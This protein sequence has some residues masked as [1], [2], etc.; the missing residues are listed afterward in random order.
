MSSRYKMLGERYGRATVLKEVVPSPF[1][2]RQERTF[3][4]QCDCGNIFNATGINLRRGHTQSCGCLQRENTVKA[5][6]THG[7]ASMHV[8]AGKAKVYNLWL[9]I[10]QR[11]NNPQDK[12]YSNYGGRGISVCKEWEDFET[13]FAYIGFPPSKDHSID[14]IDNEGNYEPGNVRWATPKEQANN[15]RK[16][17][18]LTYKNKTQTLAQWAV[19]LNLPYAA[20]LARLRRG[21]PAQKALETEIRS[22]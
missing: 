9:R 4:C 6:S 22:Y 8:Q 16:N 1:L 11:C 2:R 13:F 19:E 14:R 10:R 12:S 7:A 18:Y 20:I 3:Q 15:T 17:I 5:L 21:W